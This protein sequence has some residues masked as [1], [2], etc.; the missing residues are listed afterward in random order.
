MRRPLTRCVALPGVRVCVRA[1]RQVYRPVDLEHAQV[2]LV[3]SDVTPKH[4]WKGNKERK[5]MTILIVPF[6]PY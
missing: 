6:N 3:Q 1:L 4:S 5:L 2:L